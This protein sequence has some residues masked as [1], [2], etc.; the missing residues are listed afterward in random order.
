V[1]TGSATTVGFSLPLG[2]AVP[3]G[4]HVTA[5]ATTLVDDDNNPA[6]SRV[7][8]DTPEFS[9]V[10]AVLESITGQVFLDLNADGVKQPGEPGLKDRTLYLDLNNNGVQDTGEPTAPT[11]PSGNYAFTGLAP[12]PTSSAT[13]SCPAGTSASRLRGPTWWRLPGSW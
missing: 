10:V 2:V 7:P 8:R 6:T 4:Q 13:G 11:D 12:A 5:T 9:H 3:G 1:A